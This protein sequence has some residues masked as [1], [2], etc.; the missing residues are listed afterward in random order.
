MMGCGWALQ[1]P[2]SG[3][4]GAFLIRGFLRVERHPTRAGVP[5]CSNQRDG[6]DTPRIALDTSNASAFLGNFTPKSPTSQQLGVFPLCGLRYGS[7]TIHGIA[8]IATAESENV[9]C[10]T[11]SEIR[12]PKS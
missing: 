1:L 5:D 11:E 4:S 9:G 10:Y 6:D 8:D 2:R 3:T 12:A 7:A